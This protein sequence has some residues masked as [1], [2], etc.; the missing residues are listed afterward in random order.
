MS[1]SFT[2]TEVALRIAPVRFKLVLCGYRD[3]GY[4][5]ANIMI[6]MRRQSLGS[7]EDAHA[8][9]RCKAVRNIDTELRVEFTT[10]GDKHVVI[11][12]IPAYSRTIG[13]RTE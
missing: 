9:I 1:T 6:K 13:S 2:I 3:L 7:F 12:Y 4:R 5:D 8:R 10:V 11:K